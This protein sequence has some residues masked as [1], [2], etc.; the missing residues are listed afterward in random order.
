MELW[1]L[2]GGGGWGGV[3]ALN[4]SVLRE[5]GSIE[6]DSDVVMFIYREDRYKENSQKPNQAEIMVA[7]HRNGPLGDAKLYF[8]DKKSSFVSLDENSD[9]ESFDVV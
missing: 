9:F 5:S 2:G 4:F 3:V 7:K 8:D 6:Q 1:G